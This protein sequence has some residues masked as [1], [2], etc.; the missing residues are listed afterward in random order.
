MI[1]L[2]SIGLG[3]AAVVVVGFSATVTIAVLLS[4]MLKS[5]Q[6]FWNPLLALRHPVVVVSD[7]V[8]SSICLGVS[9]A[10]PLETGS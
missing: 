2:K 6:V 7:G 4:R 3:L 10:G 5:G 8:Y 1:W 9:S